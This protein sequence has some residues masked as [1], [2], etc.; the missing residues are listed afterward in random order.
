MSEQLLTVVAR[1]EA[2]PGKE[3]EVRN[4]LTKLLS[5]TRAEQGCLHYELHE[6][7]ERPGLFLFYETWSDESAL[8]A[9]F[10][11][12]HLRNLAARTEELLVRPAEITKWHKT[13]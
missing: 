4:E 9:H 6:S 2:R 1:I 8:R 11:T 12:P 3:Q 7:A 10:E 13:K 5:P